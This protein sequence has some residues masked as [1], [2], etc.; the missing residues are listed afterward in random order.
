MGGLAWD[1]EEEEV[2]HDNDGD[3]EEPMKM[4]VRG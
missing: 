2:G 3:R 1:M 4:T